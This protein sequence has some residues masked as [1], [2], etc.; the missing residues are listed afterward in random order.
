MIKS[1]TQNK[2]SILI[3][4]MVFV[5]L[6]SAT[7]LAFTSVLRGDIELVKRATR[8]EQAKNIAESGINHAR[9]KLE[10][11]GFDAQADFT[12]TMD[13]GSYAVTFS[14]I[15]TRYLVTSVGTS[16]GVSR[17]V[18]VEIRKNAASALDYLIGVGNTIRLRCFPF[19][20]ISLNGDI[21]ANDK[22]YLSGGPILGRMDITGEVS[23]TGE[24]RE[25]TIHYLQ[26][27]FDE[28]VYINGQSNDSATVEEGAPRIDFPVFDYE[29]HKAAATASGD[30]YSGNKTFTDT[31]LSPANGIVYVE[32]IAT[33]KGV[34]TVSG[35][36]VADKIRINGTLIQKKYG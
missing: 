22:V 28:N 19:A 17:I 1:R 33:F 3:L 24:V 21:R 11:E 35:G 34:C 8:N 30:Y 29:S 31:T 9:A 16:G 12:T 32:G 4:V 5:L 36:I 20:A 23:A 15:G 26:D 10:E 6:M 7:V 2:G 27:N 14:Q 25:G 13:T 18:A